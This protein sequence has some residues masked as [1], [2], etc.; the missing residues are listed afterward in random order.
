M[1][2]RI[3]FSSALHSLTPDTRYAHTSHITHMEPRHAHLPD[4]R[5]EFLNGG[6]IS[7]VSLKEAQRLAHTLLVGEATQPRPRRIHVRDLELLISSC[8]NTCLAGVGVGLGLRLGEG[9]AL[10]RARTSVFMLA[11]ACVLVC[12]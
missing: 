8:Q 7:G 5:C 10:L 4:G 9:S 3:L 6:G 11:I 2:A 12:G 1:R